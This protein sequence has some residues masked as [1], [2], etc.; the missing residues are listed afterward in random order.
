MCGRRSGRT[1]HCRDLDRDKWKHI[2]NCLTLQVIVGKPDG[3]K[4]DDEDEDDSLEG[5]YFTVLFLNIF[6]SR[7]I[8]TRNYRKYKYTNNT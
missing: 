7:S 8:F 4:N 5:A 2:I 6:S 3:K 1:R